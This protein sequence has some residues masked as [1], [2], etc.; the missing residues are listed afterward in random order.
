MRVYTPGNHIG[1]A[2][3][4]N[5]MKSAMALKF[6]AI[7]AFAQCNSGDEDDWEG[8]VFWAK[9][10]FMMT[11]YDDIMDF[12]DMM[13]YYPNSKET[14]GEL[15]LTEDGCDY[16]RRDGF[17]WQGKFYLWDNSPSMHQLKTYLNLKGLMW[18]LNE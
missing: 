13:K 11:D 4:I 3:F 6:K 8:Y 2:L 14:L 16:W 18:M 5:Q 17:G 9:I 15:V 12:E 10:G 7:S 1:K